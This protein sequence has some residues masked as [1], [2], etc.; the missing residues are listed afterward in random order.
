MAAEI[1]RVKSA[2]EPDWRARERVRSNG[3]HEIIRLLGTTPTPREYRE[4]L[5]NLEPDVVLRGCGQ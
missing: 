2:V 1:E 4:M 5:V 3:L